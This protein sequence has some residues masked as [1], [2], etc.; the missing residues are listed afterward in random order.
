MGSNGV[1]EQSVQLDP[2]TFETLDS[3]AG[4]KSGD[5]AAS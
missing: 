2:Q 1:I 3:A 4:H 5:R